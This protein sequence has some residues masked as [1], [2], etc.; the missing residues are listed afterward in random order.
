MRLH[1]ALLMSVVPAFA[2]EPKSLTLEQALD[3]AN[4]QQPALRQVRAGVLASDA[5][6]RQALA[7][8]LPTISASLVY[9]RATANFVARPGAVPASINTLSTSSFNSFDFFSGNVTAQLTLW[10][11]LQN[12]NRYQ[13]ALSSA[14]AQEAQVHA[15][16]TV[17]ALN[18]RTA[19]H[20]AV[21]Q[22]QLV[23]VA[24]STLQNSEAHLSQAQGFVAVGTRPEIDLAQ[25][26]VERANARL[27]LLSATN[28]AA[29]ARA[30]LNQ[31]MGVE[32]GVPYVL[33]SE[34]AEALRGEQ[35]AID[36]LVVEAAGGRPEM[37][38]LNAQVRAQEWV[39]QSIRGAYLPTLGVQLQGTAAARDLAQGVPNLSAQL[40]LNWP[41]WQGGLTKAQEA[42]AEASLRALEAQRDGLQLQVRLDV[43]TAVL[44]VNAAR[45]GVLVAQEAVDAARQRL[46]LAEGRYSAGAGSAIERGDAQAAATASEA[47]AVGAAMNLA[48][49]RSQLLAALGRPR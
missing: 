31:A 30:R 27:A 36:T 16:E 22:Q 43:E 9:S 4:A 10:D 25:S 35:N 21:A 17:T 37:T 39:L 23:D 3:I 20:T 34:P 1:F 29:I 24:K 32:A 13:G 41:L 42:E 38:A 5:R 33:V 6:S 44:N 26:K 45:E 28:A 40:T 11:F 47:Q 8:M 14:Q 48:V 2:E 19:W 46:K 18:V 7:P 15:A 12:W 49:A